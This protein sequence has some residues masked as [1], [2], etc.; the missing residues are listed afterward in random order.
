M[1]VPFGCV[2]LLISF[3]VV[4]G[5]GMFCNSVSANVT[6]KV[7]FRNGVWSASACTRWIFVRVLALVFACLRRFFDVSMPI[8]CLALS[9]IG[10]KSSPV[11]H[12]A[13]NTRVVSAW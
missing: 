6:V 13:S 5:L 11:P 2:I 10:L 1:I 4:F 12:P 9:A 3:R 7:L 8:I